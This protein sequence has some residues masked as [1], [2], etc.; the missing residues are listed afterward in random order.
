M[1]SR[2]WLRHPQ[3][4]ELLATA[5]LTVEGRLGD[6]SNTTLRCLASGPDGASLRVVVKPVSG[7][8]PLWDFPE[9]TLGHRELAAY[10]LSEAI[11]WQLVPPTVWR[12][13]G[14]GGE[15]MCQLWM[16]TDPEISQVQVVRPGQCPE[17]FV[18]V[19]EAEDGRGRPVELVHATTVD[20]VRVAVFDVIVNNADRKGGHVLTD[21]DGRTWAIDHGVTFSADD[22]LRTVLWGWAGEPVPSAVLDDV[23]RLHDLLGEGFDPVDRW[24]AEDEREALRDRVR[25]LVRTGTFPQPSGRWPAIPWPV[26]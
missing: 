14:P 23:R 20:V 26:F 18:T 7:E 12:P 6:A 3:L 13:D 4:M 25:H 10:A 2:D 19:F 15:G 21:L 24:L 16:D 5:D 22:K 11:G 9:W 17:G 8:R 1:T